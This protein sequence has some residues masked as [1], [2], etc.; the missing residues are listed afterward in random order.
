MSIQLGR[1]GLAW[2][3]GA[4][5][6]LLTVTGAGVAGWSWLS[7]D[8]PRTA[9]TEAALRKAADMG[10]PTGWTSTEPVLMLPQPAQ[11]GGS[12]RRHGLTV[13]IDTLGDVE[14]GFAATWTTTVSPTSAAEPCAALVD[15]AIRAVD[16]QEAADL[17]S[18]CRAVVGEPTENAV[19]SSYGK[20]LDSGG[21]YQFFA[22]ADGGGEVDT[23]LYATL[24]F[25]AEN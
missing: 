12:E 15:W 20:S 7:A 9:A 17:A 24:I 18:S 8:D 1:R 23:T 14:T 3:A 11:E 25:N 5:F 4:A 13:A 22:F 6:A 16:D 21:R 19:F 2:A 10:G